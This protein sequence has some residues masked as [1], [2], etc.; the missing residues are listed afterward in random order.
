[1]ADTEPQGHATR[2]APGV[3]LYVY[4]RLYM[5]VAE[6]SRRAKTSLDAQRM[7]PKLPTA[8]DAVTLSLPQSGIL[9]KPAAV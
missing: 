4:R 5:H 9:A 1:M 8:R 3:L 7:Q 6:R 2:P